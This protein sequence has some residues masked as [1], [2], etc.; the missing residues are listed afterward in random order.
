MEA[1]SLVPSGEILTH[2]IDI[3]RI[4]SRNRPISRRGEYGRHERRAE[5]R[6]IE[7]GERNPVIPPR[8]RDG[9]RGFVPADNSNIAVKGIDAASSRILRGDGLTGGGEE[10]NDHDT[11]GGSHYNLRR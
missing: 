8:L 5:R 3:P 2:G 7:L 1:F 6:G 9:N 4:I 11:V 10:Q